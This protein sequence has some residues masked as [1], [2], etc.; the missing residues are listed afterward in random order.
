MPL[1]EMNALLTGQQV[2]NPSFTNYALQNQT[3]GADMLDA[4][5]KQGQW[6]KDIWNQQAAAVHV[7]E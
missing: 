7:P 5:S 6:D 4:A 3:Q 2:Q 1:N